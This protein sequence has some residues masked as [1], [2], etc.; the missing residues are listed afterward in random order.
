MRQHLEIE[1]YYSTSPPFQTLDH[2]K[3]KRHN[4]PSV[5]VVCI[6]RT[7]I[8][9]S[10][11]YTCATISIL[12][13]VGKQFEVW[14]AHFLFLPLHF[15][16]KLAFVHHRRH[17]RKCTARRQNLENNTHGGRRSLSLHKE[18]NAQVQA[19]RVQKRLSVTTHTVNTKILGW[20]KR[21]L[22][23]FFITAP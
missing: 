22:F 23:S 5:Y 20:W 9:K 6:I 19:A 14:K 1:V 21:F 13:Q 3:R 16:H 12:Q 8:R 18:P 4:A 2:G 10:G 11:R 17:H 7:S 15:V